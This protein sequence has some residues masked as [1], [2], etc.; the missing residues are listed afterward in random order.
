MKRLQPRSAGVAE[1]RTSEHI[2]RDIGR[3]ES[4]GLRWAKGLHRPDLR[5]QSQR[6]LADPSSSQGF[7][8]ER[9]LAWQASTQLAPP[10]EQVRPT[11]P[12]V[13]PCT[14]RITR[15]E[16]GSSVV[17]DRSPAF[18]PGAFSWS[19]PGE[20]VSPSTI[21]VHTPFAPSSPVHT[22]RPDRKRV[23]HA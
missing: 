6:S 8:A 10:N 17:R 20:V 11:K 2:E 13:G 18:D 22:K 9:V 23:S 4:K 5:F 7:Q 3:G 21:F 16:T 19:R 1:H 12:S 14:Q 15:R